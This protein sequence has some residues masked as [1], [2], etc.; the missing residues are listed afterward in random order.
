MRQRQRV[1][2]HDG[3][4]HVVSASRNYDDAPRSSWRGQ[5][6]TDWSSA[7]IAADDDGVSTVRFHELYSRASGHLVRVAGTRVD[8]LGNHS[9]PFGENTIY[10]SSRSAQWQ[11]QETI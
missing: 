8:A 4:G 9:S 1:V 11:I 6:S 3:E 2:V 5:S 7:A 10:V